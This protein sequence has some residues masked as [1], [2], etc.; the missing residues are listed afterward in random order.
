MNDLTIEQKRALAMA[1][2]RKRM[3]DGSGAQEA[4]N[5]QPVIEAGGAGRAFT[6]G[7]NRLIPF[8]NEISSQLAATVAAPFTPETRQELVE[9]A[10]QHTEQTMQK[11]PWAAGAGTVAGVGA[12]LP[13][14]SARALIGSASE[15]G[16]RGAV[17]AIP[18]GLS[19][20]DRFVRGGKVAKDA[21]TLAKTGNIAL[22][23]AKGAT[24]AAP[25]AGLYAAGEA[26]PGERGEAFTSGA[27]LG[28]AV[29]GALP[30]AG[31]SL[32][33]AGSA[34]IPKVDEGFIE[35]AK[36]A[37]KYNIP[38]SVDQISRS[39]ALKNVQKVSQELPLSGAPGFREQQMKKLNRA[40]FK[41][42]GIE[43]DR[44]TPKTMNKAF[45]Q[46]GLEFD[47]IGKGKTLQF[48]DDFVRKIS[49]IKD[50]AQDISGADAISN[51][52]SMAEKLLKEADDTGAITGEKLNKFRSKV[53]AAARKTN[54][55][56]T[57]VLL[58][59]LESLIVD[60]LTDGQEDLIKGLAQAKQRYKNLLVLEPLAAKAKGGYISPAL[61]NDRAYRIYGREHL[62][63]K[64][65]E[66]GDLA[67]IGSELLPELGGSDTAQKL[68]YA[69][70]TIVGGTANA[71]LT[72]A[73]IA[74]NRALQAGYLRNQAL[75]GKMIKN[76]DDALQVIEQ[77]GNLTMDI[78][79]SLPPAEKNK[80]LS[81][82]MKM[83]PSRASLV[84][85]GDTSQRK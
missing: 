65:G 37:Q 74:G 52:T 21:G 63:G 14:I 38:L 73:T 47:R 20:V 5:Q 66:I 39:R 30:V 55:Y 28:A 10:R 80:F 2:A 83:A 59:D 36:L 6:Y 53:N 8:G 70:G 19:A 78:V 17:N 61:L 40:L 7:F 54:N 58:H 35:V 4:T 45:E 25:T 56:D 75:V 60:K 69:V 15:K 44:F 1:N 33:A 57:K 13:A 23:S 34:I 16:I 76:A 85:N 49:V 31:A 46:V 48:D 77:G 27:G 51:F 68:L 3:E 24:V 81:K 79:N 67:R 84:T 43:A 71:P 22:Q 72:A 62:R 29:G 64:S 82:V 9:Q 12:T 18:Q 32:G 50:E 26:Q 42:V 11:H 41:T